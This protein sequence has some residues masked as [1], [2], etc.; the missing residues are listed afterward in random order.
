MI[1]S[2]SGVYFC[3]SQIGMFR[4]NLIRAL[5]KSFM[6]DSDMLHLDAMPI[7]VRL[8]AAKSGFYDDMPSRDR[9]RYIGFS[10]FAFHSVHFTLILK[11]A[12]A[13]IKTRNFVPASGPQPETGLKPMSGID[14]LIGN[15]R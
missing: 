11:F 14:V 7:D 9:L 6:P 4:D 2:K 3:E 8:S 10:V 1:V 15:S 13:P 12:Q 5:T